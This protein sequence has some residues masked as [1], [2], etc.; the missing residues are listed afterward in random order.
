[1]SDIDIGRHGGGWGVYVD[2]HRISSH[3]TRDGAATAANNLIQA[4]A[5]YR[6]TIRFNADTD[7]EARE[8]A[9]YMGAVLTDSGYDS[10]LVG[11]R[12]RKTKWVR[13][14]A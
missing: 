10:D 13:P 7:A 11:L 14:D 8:V 3:T 12:R 9:N 1:M 5:L 6:I 2:G 4:E